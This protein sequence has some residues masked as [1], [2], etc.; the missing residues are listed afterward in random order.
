MLCA[1]GGDLLS[2]I[3]TSPFDENVTK[4]IMSR[5]LGALSYLHAQGIWHRDIKLENLLVMEHTLSPDC[6]VLAD[7]GF[8]GRFKAGVC[9]NS[10]PGTL[11][12]AA[13]ELIARR[14]YNEKVDI[15]ALGIVMYACLT[16]RY[17]FDCADRAS[18][19]A[20]ITAGLPGLFDG[21]DIEISD[22]A[23][24]LLD[25]MLTPDP[26]GRAT[27]NAALGHNWFKDCSTE[28][29]IV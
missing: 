26:T 7:F 4:S 27:A 29:G 8:S 5:V 23:R 13:P 6:V 10:F 1:S 18:V 24:D 22:D 19:S 21:D 15:W 17:P 25:W 11:F 2:W 9:D 28:R 3:Q 12:Y 16:G 20:E 14:P